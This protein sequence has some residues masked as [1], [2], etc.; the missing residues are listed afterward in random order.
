[1]NCRQEPRI[2]VDQQCDAIIL[3]KP[4]E[5]VTCR[6]LNVSPSG[7]L[8]ALEQPVGQARKVKLEWG[9][10]FLIGD[11]RYLRSIGPREYHVGLSLLTC[12]EWREPPVDGAQYRVS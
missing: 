8:I 11:V 5:R 10:N 2:E 12:S 4:D 3:G 6:V 7:I 1:M 9:E